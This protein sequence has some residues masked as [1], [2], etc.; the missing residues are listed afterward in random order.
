MKKI[1]ALLLVIASLFAFASC[2][3]EVEPVDYLAPFRAAMDSAPVSARID[4]KLENEGASLSGE[5]IINYAEGIATVN[6]K[7]QLLGTFGEESSS[8]EMVE[9]PGS[10]TVDASGAVISGAIGANYAALVAH[11]V[12]LNPEKM[13]YS[14]SG[15]TLVATISAA[16]GAALSAGHAT[17]DVVLNVTVLDGKLMGIA[18]S[19]GTTAGKV[20]IVCD[21]VY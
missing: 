1:I 9:I 17:T 16:N 7:N 19:Y 6:F 3:E 2:D 12:E 11:K 8:S 15:N 18:V 10:A 20:S 14:I 21:Y 5:Y 4:S 13:T